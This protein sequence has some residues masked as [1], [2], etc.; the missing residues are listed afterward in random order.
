MTDRNLSSE[1]VVEQYNK[2]TIWVEWI[3]EQWM[4]GYHEEKILDIVTKLF[5]DV[6]TMQEAWH[7]Y[8]TTMGA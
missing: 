2:D 3:Q 8:K 1:E 6:D 7:H 4:E 5:G